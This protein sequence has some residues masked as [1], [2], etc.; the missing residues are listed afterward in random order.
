MQA[1]LRDA[2]GSVPDHSDYG[3]KV[4]HTN[5]FVSQSLQSYIYTI[6]SSKCNST[7]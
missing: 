1:D 2:V 7:V 6:L 4:S 3:K 5:F